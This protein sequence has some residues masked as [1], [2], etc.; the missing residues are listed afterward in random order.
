MREWDLGKKGDIIRRV[1]D[2]D[3]EEKDNPRETARAASNTD[4]NREREGDRDRERD[5]GDRDRG[6]RGER[7]DRRRR[8]AEKR[9][10]SESV[11][12]GQNNTFYITIL[13]NYTL[14]N[15]ICV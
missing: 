5:R 15:I 2:P 8:S 10:R 14:N 12:P 1:R 13:D 7:G 6:E 4:R 3:R 9:N 11:S